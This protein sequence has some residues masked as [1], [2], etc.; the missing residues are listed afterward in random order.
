MSTTTT[1]T[2]RSGLAAVRG[3]RRVL[4]DRRSRILVFIAMAAL[5]LLAVLVSGQLLQ[6]AA[7]AMDLSN[8]NQPPS[9]SDWFG[10]DRYGRDMVARTLV[11]LRFSLVVGTV[12]AASSSVIAL[13]L[14]AIAVTGGRMAETVVNWLVDFF[15]ALPHLVLLILLTF[16]MGGGTNAVIIA[17]AVTHWPTL[18]RV[19]QA[20][21]RTVMASEYVASSRALGTGWWQLVRHHLLPHLLPHFLVGTVLMF[22]HAILHEAALSFLGLGIDPSQPAIGILLS[23]A[24]GTLSNGQWWLALLPGLCLLVVVKLVDSIGENLRA[25]LDPRSF[26]L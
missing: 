25:L 7:G 3:S 26:H 18:T 22:P 2:P 19:L 14:A 20:K 11:G 24:M 5:T 16:A 9:S 12:A 15:L 10:T 13:V 8:V 23:E 6:G 4:A 21:A 17:I 1:P